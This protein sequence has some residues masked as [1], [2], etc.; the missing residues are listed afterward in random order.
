MREY[1]EIRND[2]VFKLLS[3]RIDHRDR[4]AF[5]ANCATAPVTERHFVV[6]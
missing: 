4:E 3:G 6:T 5:S 1:T 2:I